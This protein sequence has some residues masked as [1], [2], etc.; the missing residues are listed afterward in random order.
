MNENNDND[1][2]MT[3]RSTYLH[4]IHYL[5]CLLLQKWVM[6]IK[7]SI[8]IAIYLMERTK[9]LTLGI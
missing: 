6:L 3:F 4:Q 9:K 2:M 7:N 8:K 5:T 1:D